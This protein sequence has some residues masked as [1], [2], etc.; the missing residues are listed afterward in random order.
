MV[1]NNY[2]IHFLKNTS[3]QKCVLNVKIYH[4]AAN[5]SKLYNEKICRMS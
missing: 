2:H 4:R 1:E 3:S 5:Y